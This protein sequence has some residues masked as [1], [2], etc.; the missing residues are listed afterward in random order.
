MVSGSLYQTFHFQ[1]EELR[2][3]AC[4]ALSLKGLYGEPTGLAAVYLRSV[5]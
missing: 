5:H 4:L 3:E 2:G 1:V